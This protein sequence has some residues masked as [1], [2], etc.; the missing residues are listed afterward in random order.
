VGEGDDALAIF[1]AKLEL[2]A[3]PG[4]RTSYRQ[5]AYSLAAPVIEK[6][7]RPCGRSGLRP[8]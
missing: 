8:G 6:G 5:A 2:I 3:P 7:R 1:A 4:A